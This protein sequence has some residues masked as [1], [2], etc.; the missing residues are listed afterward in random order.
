MIP[1]PHR[2]LDPPLSSFFDHIAQVV[3]RYGYMDVVDHGP[4]FIDAVIEFI[5]SQLTM[6]AD[7]TGAVSLQQQSDMQQAAGSNP[8]PALV[9]SASLIQQR[10]ASPFALGMPEAEVGRDIIHICFSLHW[11]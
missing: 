1:I 10:A 3:A 4:A 2:L 9:Q 8:L 6:V 11:L 7:P 5:A